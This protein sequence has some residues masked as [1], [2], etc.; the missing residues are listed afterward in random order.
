SD[1]GSTVT[2]RGVVYKKGTFPEYVTDSITQDGGGIGQF[3]SSLT[4]LD[5]GSLYFVRAYAIN[6]VGIAYG[7][8]V[9]VQTLPVAIGDNFGGGKVAYILKPGD[10]NYSGDY[11]HGLIATP[12]DLPATNWGAYG[13]MAATP[14]GLGNG[15]V[16]TN[17]ITVTLGTGTY[18]A[19]LC[20]DLVFPLAGYTDWY[21][22]SID[23]MNQLYLNRA[24]I[25]GFSGGDYW[26]SCSYNNTLAWKYEFGV[27]S[28]TAADKLTTN[29]V[30]P[31]RSF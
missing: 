2:A 25:G 4:S 14:H 19:R 8:Q 20:A 23:E 1:G 10:P 28:Y 26:T 24:I 6:G 31:V 17:T 13:L 18:A 21:L 7:E 22:P 3:A 27:G 30:R 5:P 11:Q 15:N 9:T 12:A 29:P 16:N